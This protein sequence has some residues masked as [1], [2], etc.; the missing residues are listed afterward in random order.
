MAPK[1]EKKI[2]SSLLSA[3]STSIVTDKEA[4]TKEEEK[5]A[6]SVLSSNGGP[7]VTEKEA[8]ATTAAT[9]VES[10]EVPPDHGL[11]IRL[12]EKADGSQLPV[13]EMIPDKHYG[14]IHPNCHAPR[15]LHRVKLLHG[16]GSGTAVFGGYH[17]ELG[18]IVMKHASAKDSKEVFSLVTIHQQLLLR[19]ASTET[20]PEASEAAERMRRRI[21]EFVMV[22]ISPYHLRDRGKELWLSMLKAVLQRSGELSHVSRRRSGRRHSMLAKIMPNNMGHGDP[23][24]N[25]SEH[26]KDKLSRQETY[27]LSKLPVLQKQRRVIQEKL[28]QRKIIVVSS[29]ET[30]EPWHIERRKVEIVLPSGQLLSDGTVVDTDGA[31]FL[32][33]FSKELRRHQERQNWKVTLAQRSIGG[34]AAENGAHVLT[35]GK[36]RGDMLTVLVR[37][38]TSVMHDLEV[39]TLPE[40]RRGNLEMVV[41]ELEEL[42]QSEDMTEDVTMVSETTDD[43]VGSAICKNFEPVTGRFD[44][45]RS[46]GTDFRDPDGCFTLTPAELA[47]AYFLGLVLRTGAPLSDVFEDPPA[48]FTALDHVMDED[49]PGWLDVLEHAVS[50]ADNPAAVDSI[51]TCGLT[52]AGL[53]NT[54]LSVERGLELFDLGAPHMMPKPAF[55]TK[56]LM[57]FFHTLGMEEDGLGSWKRRFYVTG[58]DELYNCKLTVTEETAE[59]I[60]YIHRAFTYT[61]DYFIEHVFEG[62]ERVRKLLIKYVV[63]QLLSDSSFCLSRWEEKGGGK[64]RVGDRLKLPLEKWLWRSLWDQY[65]ASYVQ[66]KFLNA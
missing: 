14:E 65:I 12:I 63:L 20:G 22:F 21:P 13:L 59:K 41:A 55:L 2:A 15:A 18:D 10:L 44:L 37:E 1:G 25:V 52:D 8:T 30:Q 48:E 26:G 5:I 23:L 31:A 19:S 58:E 62:D 53:H 27:A 38:F 49:R 7:A 54:F 43:F 40:E 46:F 56:F 24:F 35:T 64:E 45:L 66:T 36:L 61:L 50:L 16:G 4:A 60:P 3:S 47:P 28:W 33:D 11:M 17:P 32:T 57:S 42:R 29:K 51:W 39:L 6:D 9:A 34:P